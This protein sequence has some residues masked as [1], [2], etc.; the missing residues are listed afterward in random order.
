MEKKKKKGFF[1]FTNYQHIC[2][3][4]DYLKKIKKKGVNKLKKK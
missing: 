4:M 2:C 1:F 3:N